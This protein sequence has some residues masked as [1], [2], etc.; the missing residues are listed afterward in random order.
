MLKRGT[1][2]VLAALVAAGTACLP[3]VAAENEAPKK[4][5]PYAV[6][7]KQHIDPATG[8]HVQTMKPATRRVQTKRVS[9]PKRG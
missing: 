6:A 8:K 9:T 7:N 5:S 1:I 2:L 3:A 4:V